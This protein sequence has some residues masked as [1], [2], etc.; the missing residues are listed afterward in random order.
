MGRLAFVLTGPFWLLSEERLQKAR[1]EA[2]EGYCSHP[3]RQRMVTQTMVV[4]VGVV[5]GGQSLEMLGR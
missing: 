1:T 2:G 4:L 3:K 5:R